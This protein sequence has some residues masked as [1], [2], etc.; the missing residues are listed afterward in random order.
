MYN[1]YNDNDVYHVMQWMTAWSVSCGA[2]V[3]LYA[4]CIWFWVVLAE[5][6]V[7]F[8]LNVSGFRYIFRSFQQLF[9]LHPS[10]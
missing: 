9:L 4:P 3:H 8:L 7:A 10:I 1:L 5:E 6:I 2:Y